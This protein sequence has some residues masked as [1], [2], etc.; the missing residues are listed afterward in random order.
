MF[1]LFEILR[2]AQ[3]G[4]ALDNVARQFGLSP[5]EARRAAEALMPAFTLGFRHSAVA[6]PMGFARLFWQAGQPPVAQ[7]FAQP[8]QAFSAQGRQQ[9]EALVGQ[10]FGSPAAGRQIAS[11]A[12]AM[13]GLGNEVLRRMLPAIAGM[14]VTGVLHAAMNQSAGQAPD[15]LLGRLSALM[16]A[17]SAPTPAPPPPAALPGMEA[18]AAFVSAFL[19]QPAAAPAPPPPPP[20]L[21]GQMFQA[22]VQVQEQYLAALRGALDAVW[23]AV[24]RRD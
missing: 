8:A 1:N 3:G 18:W 17:P 12:A 7:L 21:V 4:G 22:G 11:Q 2:H 24:P 19:G 15:D 16:G 6:D 14:I 20:D 10:L 13:T 23:G 5:D 9:G